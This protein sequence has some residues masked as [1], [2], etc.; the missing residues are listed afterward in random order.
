[1]L[2]EFIDSAKELYTAGHDAVRPSSLKG[3]IEGVAAWFKGNDQH[4][5]QELLVA[6]PS[7]WLSPI[8]QEMRSLAHLDMDPFRRSS[9]WQRCTTS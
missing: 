8:H 2:K 6:P 3:A 5:A 1:M 4:D 7:P 9:C